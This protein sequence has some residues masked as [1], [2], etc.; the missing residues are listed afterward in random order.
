MPRLGERCK[1]NKNNR[2]QKIG[3]KAGRSSMAAVQRQRPGQREALGPWST[4]H[5]DVCTR[6]KE[7]EYLLHVV[8]RVG[9]VGVDVVRHGA[10]LP[11]LHDLR[12]AHTNK[13]SND[14]V[15]L[16]KLFA[17][18]KRISGCSK[19]K[20]RARACFFLLSRQRDCRTRRVQGS[21]RLS[22]A[23]QEKNKK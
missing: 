21:T 12:I 11:L 9:G 23:G 18:L 3:Y 8:G 5:G 16:F 7:I 1:N 20:K 6:N 17:E 2:K 22:T 19:E 10:D 13:V 14:L 15:S 4:A